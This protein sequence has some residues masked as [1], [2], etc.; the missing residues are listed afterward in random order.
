MQITDSSSSIIGAYCGNQT[1]K[2]IRVVGT[3]G[4][5]IFHTDGSVQSGGFELS[6]SFFSISVGEFGAV[7]T[8]LTA[9]VY[10][11]WLVW[12]ENRHSWSNFMSP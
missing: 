7:S 10:S 8:A 6:F 5:L 4:V 2:S 1:G 12:P 11:Y 3:V 9:L